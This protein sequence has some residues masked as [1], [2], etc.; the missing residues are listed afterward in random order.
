MIASVNGLVRAIHT[1]RVVVE[2]G[3]VGLSILTTAA[4]TANLTIGSP[5]YLF[6]SMVVREDSLTLFGFLDDE[7]RSL[8]ELVQTVS[9]I[10]PKVA[11]S[12]V[13]AL[14]PSQLALAVSQEDIAAIEKVPGI[15]RKGAQRLILELK[16]KLSDFGGANTPIR[17]Q[18]I[19]RE[20]LAS[21]LISLGFSARD[22]DAAI[23][24]VVSQ[25]S[26]DGGEASEMELAHL[27]KL[28][29]QNGGR[30]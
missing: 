9:G 12:I 19:W 24:N 5:V 6:T 7:E 26:L 25:I 27:L 16:G 13:S 15:G 17:H 3:G 29:L 11:L 21:A 28:A 23:T 4:T 10:G 2:V 30:S 20:Q 22:S 14:S 8:F 1:D 18:P